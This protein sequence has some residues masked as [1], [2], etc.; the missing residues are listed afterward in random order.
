MI[1]KKC[2]VS[3]D[4]IHKHYICFQRMNIDVISTIPADKVYTIIC[5]VILNFFVPAD[6]QGI[7][8]MLA[9]FKVFMPTTIQGKFFM[10]ATKGLR[11]VRIMRYIKRVEESMKDNQTWKQVM[12]K[13]I[14]QIMTMYLV[15]HV[16]AC[17]NYLVSRQSEN[18]Q[19][20]VYA[21]GIG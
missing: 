12:I 16:N 10:L 4:I 18:T 1:T 17:L 13:L 5:T 14:N 21:R 8:M 19:S 20:W 3:L 6:I 2:R 7:K 11:L 15:A 9:S